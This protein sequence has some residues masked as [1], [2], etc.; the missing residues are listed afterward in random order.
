M[1]GGDLAMVVDGLVE[2]GPDGARLIGSRCNGCGTLY[3]PQTANCPN[4]ACNNKHLINEH[5]PAEGS[6]WSYTIQRYQPPP[7]FR[8]DDWQPYILGLVD[9]G[10]G[11][12]VMGMLTGISEADVVIGMKLRVVLQPLYNDT[13]T[14]PVG[15]Y[16]FA[17]VG[18][19]A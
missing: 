10:E 7:L 14:G 16:M 17:T 19:G 18:T 13:A 12:R 8:M 1:M 9:M 5:L 2:T 4:P 11:V 6:L 3:F 15:S